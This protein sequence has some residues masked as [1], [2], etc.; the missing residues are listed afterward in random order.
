MEGDSSSQLILRG[1]AEGRLRF[2]DLDL[3]YRQDKLTAIYRL[4]GYED[5]IQR[6]WTENLVNQ[7]GRW[8][9]AAAAIRSMEFSRIAEKYSALEDE[10]R[11]LYWAYT[12]VK[13]GPGELEDLANAWVEAFGDPNDPAVAANI[14]RTIEAIKS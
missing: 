4:R 1:V 10:F 5:L 11:L 8:L 13:A 6:E 3:R 14:Q 7:A 2:D 12:G 9:Q